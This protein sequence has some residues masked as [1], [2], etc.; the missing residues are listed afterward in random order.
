MWREMDGALLFLGILLLSPILQVV[1]EISSDLVVSTTKGKIQGFDTSTSHGRTVSAWYGVPFAQPPIG[2]LRFRHPRPIDSWEGVKETKQ[3]PNSCIQIKDTMWEG[4]EGSEAW[5]ANTKL[6][7]DCLYLNVVVPKPHPKDAAV[8]LWIYGGG[9]WGGTTTL[10]L[11]DLRTIVSE[12]NVIAVGIQYRVASLAFLYFDTEDVP[13]NAG[14]F[15]QLMALQWVKDNIE[16]FGGNPNNITLMGESAGA[17]SVSLHLLS[18]LSRHLF[19]QAIMQSASATAP[20]GVITK[21]ESLLRGLRLAELMDC[22]HD[23]KNI[24]GAIECLRKA[25]A[26]DMVYKEWN[27]IT[28]GLTIGIFTP[29]IDGSF[30]DEKPAVSLKRK[31]FKKTNILMG[32]NKDEGMF[33]IFYYMADL[34]PKEEDVFI[35]REDFERSI[36][37]LNVYA[38]PLQRKAIE[39]EY[40]NWLNPGDPIKNREEVDRFTGDW[41]FTCPVVEFA[42]RY[43][44]TGNNVYM[45][46]FTQRASNSPWPIWSGALHAD[47]IAFVFGQP[48]NRSKNYNDAEIRLSKKMMTYW[49]NF[50]KT[51]NPSLSADNT[52]TETYWPLHTPMKREVMHLNAHK[53]EVLEGLRVKKCAFWRK[54]LPQLATDPVPPPQPCGPDCCTTNTAPSSPTLAHLVLPVLLLLVVHLPHLLLQQQLRLPHWL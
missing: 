27:G 43:A 19:S 15:D 38:N 40:T 29:I 13:G 49:A 34:F 50:A 2:N 35:N 23:R 33:F 47:E 46:Y 42:H 26:T 39:F 3:L 53:S 12:E 24:R 54:F 31:E 25:N 5:N 37:E 21:E 17:C 45:Y 7:E 44:E 41:Q 14:M 28:M 48:L 32:A 10:D 16:Q 4:F 51:G 18:P 1:A 52:W 36:T 30:L 20:W 11:Y 9:F 22:P 6:S 8:L